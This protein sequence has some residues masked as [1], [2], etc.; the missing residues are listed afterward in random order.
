[1]ASPR[2]AETD[3]VCV[4]VI[5]GPHGIRG[6]VRVKSFTAEPEDI[7]AYGPVVDEFG[8]RTFTLN[9]VGRSKGVVLCALKGVDDRNAAEMLRGVRLHVDRAVLPPPDEDD[10]FYHAD[11]IGLRVEFSD[12][13][14]LGR[15]AAVYDFGAGDILEVRADNGGVT[16]V[17]FT[18]EAVPT[19]DM[20]GGRLIAERLAGLIEDPPKAPK[21]RTAAKDRRNKARPEA[22]TKAA[23]E[24]KDEDW[25]DEDWH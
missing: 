7:A 8:A 5:V 3:R 13:V 18:R 17:P 25:P 10:E 19:I 15:V 2:D 1:M 12:G 6:Q 14:V 20:A 4:G 9:V 21:P 16:M 11:L 23:V 24:P 22:A